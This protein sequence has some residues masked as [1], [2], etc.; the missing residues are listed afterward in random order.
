MLAATRGGVDEA[1]AI[2]SSGSPLVLKLPNADLSGPLEVVV[3]DEHGER[4]F[5]QTIQ[6]VEDPVALPRKLHA[7]TYWV[8][9]N[10]AIDHQ[11]LRE[12]GLRIK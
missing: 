6:N 11:P 9:A 8:R 10:R 1:F 12:F 2:A 5:A 3:V 4:V 7:G